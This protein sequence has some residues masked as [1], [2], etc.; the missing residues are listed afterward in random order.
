MEL[1]GV[2]VGEF[3]VTFAIRGH[4]ALES[5]ELANLSTMPTT[6]GFGAHIINY[7]Y[8]RIFGFSLSDYIQYILSALIEDLCS[9]VHRHKIS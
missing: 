2:L 9:A 1:D 3:R 4:T 6:M 7:G 8:L 5:R